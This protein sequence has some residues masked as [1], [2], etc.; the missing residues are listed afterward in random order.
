[1]PKPPRI[2]LR[3]ELTSGVPEKLAGVCE[4]FGITKLAVINK[5][6]LWFRDQPEEIQTAILELMPEENSIEAGR[7]AIEALRNKRKVS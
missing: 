2:I 6:I 1:M 4:L 5:A 3:V 7:W